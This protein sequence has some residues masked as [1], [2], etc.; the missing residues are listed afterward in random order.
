MA[1][2]ASG[3]RSGLSTP[4]A[5]VKKPPLFSMVTATGCLSAAGAPISCGC[6]LGGSR[7]LTACARLCITPVI[8]SSVPDEPASLRSRSIFEIK[9]PSYLGS[10]SASP[11][12]WL[13][14]MRPSK[15]RPA[16]AVTTT[17]T[18]ARPCGMRTRCSMPTAGA[19]TKLRRMA[20]ATGI[21]I[22]RPRYKMA[23][24]DKINSDI[25]SIVTKGKLC[26][27]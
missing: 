14:N 27:R 19:T 3:C 21:K 12:T 22:S 9:V 11:E 13:V 26:F 24:I 16:T 1:A 4:L 5:V 18:T 23:E 10:S 8:R 15:P 6:G 20:R 7:P 25:T 2:V 17:I